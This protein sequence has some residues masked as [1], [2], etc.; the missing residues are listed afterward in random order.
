MNAQLLLQ[1]TQF[2]DKLLKKN[3]EP[4]I[5]DRSLDWGVVFI[6]DKGLAKLEAFTLFGFLTNL[7]NC[8]P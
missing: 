5:F 8:I 7:H 6:N 3:I 4:P 2:S 1:K